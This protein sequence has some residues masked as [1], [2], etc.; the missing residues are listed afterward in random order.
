MPDSTPLPSK[1]LLNNLELGL[2][3]IYMY[4]YMRISYNRRTEEEELVCKMWMHL[5]LSRPNVRPDFC[6]H[7]S[8][9][10]EATQVCYQRLQPHLTATQG[11]HHAHQPHMMA[12]QVR[13][14]QR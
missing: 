6:S 8:N 4:Y 12:T 5:P 3:E 7:H 13:Y 1:A 2:W 11:P 14:Q 9:F 10:Q